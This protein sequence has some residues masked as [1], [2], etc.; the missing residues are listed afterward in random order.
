M[1][2]QGIG[3]K[4]SRQQGREVIRY[5]AAAGL[6]PWCLGQASTP[7]NRLPRGLPRGGISTQLAPRGQVRRI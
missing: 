3:R 7:I 6:A 1:H 4:S 5:Q 2:Q